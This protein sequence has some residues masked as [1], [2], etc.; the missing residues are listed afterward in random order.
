MISLW[1]R[2]A[3]RFRQGFRTD[4]MHTESLCVMGTVRSDAAYMA[5]DHG[6]IAPDG[7]LLPALGPGLR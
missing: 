5:D 4:G 2:E 3:H 6:N 7:S 1:A